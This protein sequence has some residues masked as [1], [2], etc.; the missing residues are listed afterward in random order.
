MPLS[1]AAARKSNR[2]VYCKSNRFQKPPP[3]RP[4]RRT[5]AVGDLSRPAIHRDRERLTG[6]VHHARAAGGIE[7]REFLPRADTL[8]TRASLGTAPAMCPP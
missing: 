6:D 2:A 7:V 4:R 5:A 3:Y 8:P 1:S